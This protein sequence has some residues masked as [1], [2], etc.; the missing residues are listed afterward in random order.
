VTHTRVIGEQ[1]I[2]ETFSRR[3]RK[4]SVMAWGKKGREER[5][6]VI[7]EGG[8]LSGRKAAKAAKEYGRGRV[9]DGV[10]YDTKGRVL[11]DFNKG[12]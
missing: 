3:G 6:K 8:A 4:R 9:I 2:D 12:R 1:P 7:R 10:A 5:A 11:K